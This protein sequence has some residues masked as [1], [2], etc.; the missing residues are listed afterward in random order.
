M[1]RALIA[2]TLAVMGIAGAAQADTLYTN[3]PINGQLDSFNITNFAISDSFTL[4]GAATLTGVNF[5]SWNSVGAEINGLSWG[6]TSDPNDYSTDGTAAVTLSGTF[7]NDQGYEVGTASFALPSVSLDAGTYYLVLTGATTSTG[8][9]TFWDE[10]N[11]PSSASAGGFGSLAGYDIP[12]TTG[13]ESFEI[14]GTAAGDTGAVPEPAS[15]ALMISGFG[16]VG[17][18]L[19][20]SRRSIA[21]AA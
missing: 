21:V 1:N 9:V 18:A 13:S 11:G 5:G 14:L 19:R 4:T 16:M 15:W 17:G 8:D 3:G 6:I 12:G 10:N 7:I 2:A 20:A